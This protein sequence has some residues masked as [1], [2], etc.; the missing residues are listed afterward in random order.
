MNLIILFISGINT[1]LF[2][3]II[4]NLLLSNKQVAKN[5]K[6]QSIPIGMGISFVFVM[7]VNSIIIFIVM[8]I[9]HFYLLTILIG[10]LTMSFIGIIDDLIGNRDSLGF[11]GH[12]KSFFKSI[13]TTGFLKLL[14]GGLVAIFISLYYSSGLSELL[15]NILLICLFTNLINLFDLRPGRAIKICLLLAIILFLIGVPKDLEII[16][17]SIVGFCLVYLPQDI[18]AL[19]MMGDVGS[20]PL[21]ISLGIVT[22]TSLEFYYKI[23]VLTLLVLLHLFAEKYSIT[24]SIENNRIL[25]FLD[26]LGRR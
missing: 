6:G 7:L 2:L 13:V 4:R 11:K 17:V 22:I 18:K 15:I 20:N 12:I 25:K 23:V 9:N 16:L 3:P 14:I 8:D 1:L 24:K 10:I 21:G 5:Y 19:S 26:D